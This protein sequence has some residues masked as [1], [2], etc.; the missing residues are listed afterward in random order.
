MI[1]EETNWGAD[2]ARVGGIPT[3]DCRVVDS[4]NL[5]GYENAVWDLF[6][7]KYDCLIIKGALS[8][9]I[10]EQLVTGSLALPEPERSSVAGGWTFPPIF[11]KLAEQV[12][13]SGAAMRKQVLGEYFERC[14]RIAK[15][16]SNY[17]G[18]SLSELTQRW[19]TALGGGCKIAVPTGLGS[20]GEYAGATLRTFYGEGKGQISL[21]CGNY[22]QTVHQHFYEHLEGQV[23][24]FDQLSFFFLIQEP[25]SGGEISLFDIQWEEGQTKATVMENNHIMLPDIS[26]HTVSA[27]EA[28]TLMPRPG[29]LVIFAAGQIW[30]R[31]EPVLGQRERI[32]LGGFAAYSYDKKTIFHWS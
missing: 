4:T 26:H 12:A 2:Q 9:S 13:S 23:D 6:K 7:R 21:Q 16:P 32:T 11:Y 31:V 22:L 25:E 18:I 1:M 3:W 30:H 27:D 14:Q 28:Q 24:V 20:K 10:C 29:D 15:D 5:T 8:A 19:L 17:L